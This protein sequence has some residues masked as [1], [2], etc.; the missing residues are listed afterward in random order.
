M[1]EFSLISGFRLT[2]FVL[3][4]SRIFGFVPGIIWHVRDYN[5]PGQSRSYSAIITQ[6]SK[7]HDLWLF[8]SRYLFKRREIIE[9]N[10]D[11]L[12]EIQ[13][14]VAHFWPVLVIKHSYLVRQSFGYFIWLISIIKQLIVSLPVYGEANYRR[15]YA[16]LADCKK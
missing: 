16:F 15:C 2:F 4:L 10:S 8:K 13:W 14:N 3:T 6:I 5:M 7:Y 12:Q 9:L 11:I 1:G